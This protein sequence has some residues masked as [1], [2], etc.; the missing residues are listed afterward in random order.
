MPKS[1]LRQQLETEGYAVVPGVVPKPNV[2]AVVADLWKHTGA[3]PNDPSTWYRPDIIRPT[4]MV[5]MYHYQ[6]MWDNRQL[7]ALH[8]VFT[9]IHGTPKL[10]VSL[11]R[12]NLKPPSVPEHPEY[13][14]KGF[15]HWDTELEKYPDIPFRVQCV[16]AL[17]DTEADMGGF[18]CVPE[19]YRDLAAY[20]ER[21]GPDRKTQLNGH[22]VTKV[23]LRAGDLVIWSTLMAHGNGNNL[24]DRP[25]LAQYVSMNPAPSGSADAGPRIEAWRNNSPV[26]GAN[27]FPGDPRRIE[28]SRSEPAKL[29]GLGR[30]LLG[31]DPWE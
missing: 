16:L 25:R 17:A 19:I 15:V 29:T 4:G 2:D 6:S 9:E 12:T 22:S 10:W 20:I 3:D 11:D 28:E 31:L 7:P 24:S 14:H 1:D 18:Q 30:K 5:E 8:E 21:Y 23:P 13:E 27:A 26:A